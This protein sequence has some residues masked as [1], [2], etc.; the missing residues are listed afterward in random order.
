MSSTTTETG[1][2]ALGPYYDYSNE[3]M[4]PS[5]LGIRRDGDIFSGP[6]Q[7][8]RNVAGVQYYVDTMAF[9]TP[10]KSIMGNGADFPQSPLGLN[11]FFNTGQQCSNG[12]DMYQ[13]MSTIPTGIPGGMGKGLKAALGA[14][15]QGLAPGVLQ[16]SMEAMN[17]VP[18]FNAVMGTGYPKCK[19]ME[20]PVGNVNGQ[21]ASRFPKPIYNAD[22]TG[23]DDP[24]IEVPNIWVDPTADKVY[25]KPLPPG[26]GTKYVPSGPQPFMRRWVFDKWISQ[27]EYKWTQEQ[28]RHMGRLYT[29]KDIP[30][31]NTPPDPPIPSQPSANQIKA[32]IQDGGAE[33]FSQNSHHLNSEQVTA[34]LLFAGLFVGLVAFTALRK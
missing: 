30:D 28:L 11:Y 26:D 10:T 31:Q 4:Y 27:D 34:G 8:Y 21:L 2:A 20:A 14:N 3:M 9:G 13:Y 1:L 33:G 22:P 17:P 6:D 12:A 19:L 5:E 16:D 23:S 24:P 32:A 25:Y 18:M 7:I 15:L 29:S